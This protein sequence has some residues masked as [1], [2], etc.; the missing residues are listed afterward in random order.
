MRGNSMWRGRSFPL[1][2]ER[3]AG[4]PEARRLTE[5]P[6]PRVG[7]W[8]LDWCRVWGRECGRDA[9]DEWCQDDG[10]WKA[11]R[12]R[13]AANIGAATSMRVISSGQVCNC[14][15]CDGFE[16]VTCQR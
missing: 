7:N 9:A 14:T 8:R 15:F 3:V 16:N 1:S 10:A 2:C 13:K 12:V 4:D 6:R 5:H 11:V